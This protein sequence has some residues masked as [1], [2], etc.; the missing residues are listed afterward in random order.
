MKSNV[1]SGGTL[2][3]NLI[4]RKIVHDVTIKCVKDLLCALIDPKFHK[5]LENKISI[6]K[7]R[8]PL[9]RHF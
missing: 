7:Y 2:K 8:G 9:N 1:I 3:R 4:T 5:E 6:K